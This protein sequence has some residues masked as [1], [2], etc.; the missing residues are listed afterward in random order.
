VTLIERSERVRGWPKRWA[1]TVIRA[2]NAEAERDRLRAEV[3]YLHGC[4]ETYN[5]SIAWGTAEVNRLRAALE[6]AEK[7][8]GSLLWVLNNVDNA[9]TDLWKQL[10]NSAEIDARAALTA[11]RGALRSQEVDSHA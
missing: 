10:A 8:Y 11:I 3:K 2:R 7:G 1:K 9:Q 6:E 4:I 5:E